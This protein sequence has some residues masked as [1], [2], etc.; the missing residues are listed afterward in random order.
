MPR[1]LT[2]TLVLLCGALGLA[3][4]G[5]PI[6]PQPP[7]A[8]G[9][10]LRTVQNPDGPGAFVIRFETSLGFLFSDGESNVTVIAGV[11]PDQLAALCAGGEFTFEPATEQLVFRPDGSIHQLFRA[12]G[13]T[14]LV[15]EGANVDF[16]AVSPF[17][18]G[19]GNFTQTDNDLTVSGRRTNSFGFRIRGQVSDGSGGRTHVLAK[20]HA[21]ITRSG[22]FRLLTSEIKLN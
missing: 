10:T 20:F 8:S 12:K 15:F 7:G 6:S 13:V 17:G 9:P 16:C 4:S 14:L 18:V 1:S 22:L 11:T 21:L 3:C 5:D 2:L 19:Q